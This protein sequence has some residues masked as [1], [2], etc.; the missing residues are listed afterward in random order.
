MI[1]FSLHP[2]VLSFTLCGERPDHESFEL[3]EMH[4]CRHHQRCW[5]SC[6]LPLVDAEAYVAIEPHEKFSWVYSSKGVLASV[7]RQI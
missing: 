7:N 1:L 2:R 5:R 6:V 3:G 4:S